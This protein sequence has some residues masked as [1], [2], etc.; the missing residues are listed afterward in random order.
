MGT[1]KSRMNTTDFSFGSTAAIVTSMAL[2][3][4]FDAAAVS[5]ATIVSGLLVVA[6]ADNLSDSLSIHIYQEAERLERRRAFRAT[7]RNFLARLLISLTF[8]AMVVLLPPRLMTYVAAGW[9]FTLLVTLTVVLARDRG[10][11]V[12]SEVWKHLVAAVGVFAV[13]RVVGEVVPRII[14]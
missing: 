13:S 10:A 4:G 3:I 6:L 8:V 1:W 12:M 5:R 11:N 7:V 14:G 9:S 2:I